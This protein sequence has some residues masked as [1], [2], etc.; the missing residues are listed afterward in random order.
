L[1]RRTSNSA[2]AIGPGSTSPTE[3]E[4]KQFYIFPVFSGFVG[5]SDSV[6]KENEKF[7]V[8]TKVLMK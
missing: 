3:D 6:K 8:F 7:W 5:W 1:P 4:A 2:S